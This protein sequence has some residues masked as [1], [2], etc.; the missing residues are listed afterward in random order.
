M[1]WPKAVDALWRE[2]EAARADVLGAVTG[3]SQAQSE[4]RPAP[5]EWSIGEVIDHL[6]VSEIATG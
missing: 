5:N 6:T 2:I 3:V 4:W 1:S